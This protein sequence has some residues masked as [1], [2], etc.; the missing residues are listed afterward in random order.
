MELMVMVLAI[1][2]LA[3]F[4]K[5]E[6]GQALADAIRHNSSGA[7]QVGY[8]RHEVD[9]LRAEVEGLRGE[10]DDLRGQ[11]LESAERLDFAERLLGSATTGMPERHG[12]R[13]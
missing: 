5:S 2:L 9:E 10:L 3:I 7:A 8:P 13:V 12:E 11:L 6:I 1:P 4:V